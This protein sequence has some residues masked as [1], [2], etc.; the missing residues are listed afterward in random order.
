MSCLFSL[1]AVSVLHQADGVPSGAINAVFYAVNAWLP[2]LI[3]PQ[4][5]IADGPLTSHAC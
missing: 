2:I 1:N 5:I 3:F 4:V